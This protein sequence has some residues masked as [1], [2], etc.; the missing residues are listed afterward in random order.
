[1]H[2]HVVLLVDPESN[3]ISSILPPDVAPPAIALL[4]ATLY[5][6]TGFCIFLSHSCPSTSFQ[7]A[8]AVRHSFLITRGAYCLGGIEGS[9]VVTSVGIE[10]P[11]SIIC[12]PFPL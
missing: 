12:L 8:V 2:V 4:A 11:L 9:Q 5:L 1:M 7:T 3:I 10:I 6:I